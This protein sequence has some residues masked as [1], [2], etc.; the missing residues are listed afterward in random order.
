MHRCLAILVPCI[1]RAASWSM[2]AIIQ[3]TNFV[4]EEDILGFN[5]TCKGIEANI[6]VKELLKPYFKGLIL[7]SRGKLFHFDEPRAQFFQTFFEGNFGYSIPLNKKDIF[8]F[9]PYLG[10]GFYYQKLVNWD[11]TALFYLPVG[12]LLD[13]NI[14]KYFTAGLDLS[15]L[16]QILSFRQSNASNDFK[17]IDSSIGLKVQMPL[18]LSMD[19]YKHFSIN[20]IPF[21]TYLPFGIPPYSA[22]MLNKTELQQIGFKVGFDATF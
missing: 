13:Y 2:E 1:L 21:Y 15:A 16:G 17:K 22:I 14:G 20:F 5:G 3:D 4:I 12:C 18:S 19:P 10:L 7:Y 11:K 8:R 9:N 6:T